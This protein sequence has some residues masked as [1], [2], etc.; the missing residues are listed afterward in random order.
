[1]K[2][3]KF[4]S[5]LR[6]CVVTTEYCFLD[7]KHAKNFDQ[8]VRDCEF[9]L[10]YHSLKYKNFLDSI[11]EGSESKYLLA[12]KDGEITSALP[13][14][15]KKSEIGLVVN[16]LPFFGSHGSII[17]G[18]S[19]DKKTKTDLLQC[20]QSFC[21][22]N[23][24]LSGTIVS[25]LEDPQEE[26]LINIVPDYL[27]SRRGQVTN[28]PRESNPATIESSLMSIFHQKTRNAIRKGFKSE[29][30]FEIE[31]YPTILGEL[32]TIHTENM[33]AVQGLSKPKEFFEMLFECFQPNVD[34]DIFSARTQ[35]G[36]LV[37]ALLVFYFNEWVEY[38]LP[39]T[40]T[41]YRELQPMSALIFSAMKHA[42]LNKRAKRWNWG[43]TWESQVGV[44]TF[45]SRWG[46]REIPYKY[47]TREYSN[48]KLKNQFT[49]VQLLH[50]F[51][52][53]YVL[54]FSELN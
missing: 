31:T 15:V 13:L 20:Y 39:A 49:K 41:N 50:E 4:V 27:D 45:K 7:S 3:S 21:F 17:A 23:E 40:S 48:T 46:A 32:L 1:M 2:F 33:M 37:S 44:H 14:F 36:V 9:S 47:Y 29:L 22:E 10:F 6:V 12:V 28:L 38:Y 5:C 53:F 16:S 42:I 26:I 43:G 8:F 30:I 52:H 11:L 24:V 18:K 54:P 35:D 34:F 25:N 51:E 19:V